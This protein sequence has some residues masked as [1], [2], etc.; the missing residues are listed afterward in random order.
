MA[1]TSQSKYCFR[2]FCD[3]HVVYQGQWFGLASYQWKHLLLGIDS[4][5]RVSNTFLQQSDLKNSL[6]VD[7]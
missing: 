5:E 2:L 3:H 1:T 6:G 4:A 7:V